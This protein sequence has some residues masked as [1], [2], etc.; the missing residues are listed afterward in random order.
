MPAG[1]QFRTKRIPR[2]RALLL[3]FDLHHLR[4]L[5]PWSICAFLGLAL[6]DADPGLS[7]RAG[8]VVPGRLDETR[9][10]G[11]RLQRPRLEFRME[12]HGQIPRVARQL[13][14]LDELAVGRSARDAHALLRERRLVEA[15]ELEAMAMTL[16]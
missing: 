13:R 10:Q 5:W 11:M 1:F 14:D 9:E 2:L 4:L 8:L 3:A 7:I 16:V 12:L 6:R 15:V